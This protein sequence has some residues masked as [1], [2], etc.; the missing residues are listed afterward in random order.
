MIYEIRNY[1]YEP[2]KFAAYKEWAINHALP[3]L[4][5]HLDVVGFWLDCGLEAEIDGSAPL[6]VPSA[7]VTWIIRWDSMD[8]RAEG[9]VKVFGGEGWQAVKAQHPDMDGYIQIEVK[10]AEGI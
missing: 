2:S 4:R 8:Q 3:Y 6:G 7:N 5:E 10:F 1:H 9:H